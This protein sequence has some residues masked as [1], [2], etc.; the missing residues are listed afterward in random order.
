M[1]VK[2]HFLFHRPP[3]DTAR[4]GATWRD[5]AYQPDERPSKPSRATSEQRRTRDVPSFF[6][7]RDFHNLALKAQ[8]RRFF[9]LPFSALDV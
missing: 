3:T 4:R 2:S 7:S 6:T 5:V 9:A 8:L 1:G